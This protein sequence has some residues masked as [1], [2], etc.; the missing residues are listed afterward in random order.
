MVGVGGGFD[1]LARIGVSLRQAIRTCHRV[2][3]DRWRRLCQAHCWLP[4]PD[5][6]AID[7][8]GS[9][10]GL[11]GRADGSAV[12]YRPAKGFDD[13]F[14]CWSLFYSYGMSCLRRYDAMQSSITS[15]VIPNVP[16]RRCGVRSDA[17]RCGLQFVRPRAVRLLRREY[18][19]FVD[20]FQLRHRVADKIVVRNVDEAVRIRRFARA[21]GALDQAAR[22]GKPVRANLLRID[23]VAEHPPAV[24][25]HAPKGGDG[26]ER[27]PV[28]LHDGGGRGIP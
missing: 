14:M 23:A 6:S 21:G 13:V 3:P 10:Q 28:R 26:F 20:L 2:R 27:V 8:N 25:D 4:S 11:D 17:G 5:T 16:H 12:L 18:R 22:L 1:V 24:S 15:R 9:R 7:P 19:P